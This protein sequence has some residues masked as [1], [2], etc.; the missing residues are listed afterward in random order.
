MIEILFASTASH[1]ILFVYVGVVSFLSVTVVSFS[2]EVF[3]TSSVFLVVSSV[4]SDSSV[5]VDVNV[6]VNLEFCPLLTV[7]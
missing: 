3:V 5:W 2:S 1:I 6:A 4:V 7:V